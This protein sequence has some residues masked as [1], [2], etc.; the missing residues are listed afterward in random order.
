MGGV[1]W[2]VVAQIKFQI[3]FISLFVFFSSSSLL[4]LLLSRVAFNYILTLI[5]F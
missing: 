3:V 1:G 2:I 5:L 4:L